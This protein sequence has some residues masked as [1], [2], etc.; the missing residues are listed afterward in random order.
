[1]KW[2]LAHDLGSLW[3]LNSSK[4]I[5]SFF[6]FTVW[7]N[8]A[9]AIGDWIYGFDSA[10]QP[11]ATVVLGQLSAIGKCQSGIFEEFIA[12]PQSIDPSNQ[13]RESTILQR[14]PPVGLT[15][16]R[17]DALHSRK[18]QFLIMAS[19]WS[20]HKR[21]NLMPT[22]THSSADATVQY[23]CCIH[24]KKF[25]QNKTNKDMQDTKIKPVIEWTIVCL[26][27]TQFD[28]LMKEND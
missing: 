21:S 18:L 28:I 5:I 22:R 10:H 15:S 11:D 2:V 8:D 24:V 17:Y 25:K 6:A 23:D 7:S 13:L 16:N 27:C 1:M 9:T 12:H 26:N 19:H 20:K 14:T 3:N 4:L